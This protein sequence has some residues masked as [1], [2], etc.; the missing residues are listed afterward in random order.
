VEPPQIPPSSPDRR[1]VRPRSARRATPWG[2][3]GRQLARSLAVRDFRRW[4]VSQVVSTSGTMTQSVAQAWLVLRLSG[5]GIDLGLVSAFTMVPVLLGSPFAGAVVDRV[6]KRRLLIGT[7]ASF[8]ALALL[9]GALTS[10]GLV[11]LWMVFALAGALGVVSALDGPARQVYVL[12][13]VGMEG[14]GNAIGLNE[15]VLNVS[16]VLGPA[17]GGV[18][19]ATIGVAAC[20]YVNAATFVF[21]LAVLVAQGRR[22]PG[23]AAGPPAR[24]RRGRA[25]PI[26]G[27]TPSALVPWRAGSGR[28][29]REGLAYAWRTPVIRYGLLLAASSGMLFN[30]SVALPLLATQDFHAGG[31]GYGAL[32]ATFGIGAIGGAGLAASAG[33]RPS[34]RRVRLLALVTGASVLVGAVMPD[35]AAELV[36]LTVVGLSSIWFIALANTVVQLRSA[37]ALR[38]RMMGLWVMALPGLGAVTGP[39]TGWVAQALGARAAFGLAGVALLAS[40]AAGWRAYGAV[41]LDDLGGPEPVVPGAGTA[42][43]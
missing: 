37:P 39:L 14:A 3:I 1:R 33:E 32:L 27:S 12:D 29:L 43:T 4:F 22:A 41:D 13:L 9:L 7:Q 6:D 36:A 15:V 5:R 26:T 34:G 11:R 8:T 28:A 38:G 21:P 40:G 10:S 30:L 25:R 23:G 18:L 20:F 35:L 2:A 19:L 31:G 42:P 24:S 16:R 17:T